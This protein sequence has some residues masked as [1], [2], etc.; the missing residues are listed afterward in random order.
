ML[1]LIDADIVLHRVCWT[2]ENED[3]GIAKFRADEMLDGILV[4]TK[5]TEFQLWFSDVK[6]NNFRYKLYAPYKANRVVEKPVHYETL[7]E[8]LITQWGA[9]I[10]FGME[11]DDALGIYQDK[12][13]RTTIIASI[14]KDLL[15]IPGLHWNFVKQEKTVVSAL[16]AL[17]NFYA[18]FL[19]GDSA[20]NIK[21][22]SGIGPKKAAKI[23]AGLETEE[24]MFDAVVDTFQ[25]TEKDWSIEQV[26]MHIEQIGQVLKIKQKEDEPNWHFPKSKQMT[27]ILGSLSIQTMEVEIDPSTEPIGAE[28]L[29]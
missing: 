20:D 28:A 13:N 15:T 17:R 23:L 1:A 16:E 21:G 3:L 25:R 22:A 26:L 19:I 7:K 6:E 10:A 4:D 8:Y 29:G 18:Q 5:A 12:I 27:E 11:A 2:T 24:E 14:D 9:R